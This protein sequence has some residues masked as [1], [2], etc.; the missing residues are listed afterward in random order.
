M[1]TSGRNV[2]LDSTDAHVLTFLL[3]KVAIFQDSLNNDIKCAKGNT[4]S[5]GIIYVR[6]TSHFTVPDTRPWFYW[7]AITFFHEMAFLFQIKC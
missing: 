2:T 6:W 7:N 3:L 5:D 4:G 1:V